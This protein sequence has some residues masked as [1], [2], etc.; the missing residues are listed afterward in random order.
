MKKLLG[1]VALATALMVSQAATAATVDIF[2]TQ[3]APGSSSW[4][5]TVNTSVNLGGV[6]LITGDNT[7]AFAPNPA[8]SSPTALLDLGL[9]GLSPN[10]F[11]TGPSDA[12]TLSVVNN[13]VNVG[14]PPVLTGLVVFPAGTTGGLLGTLTVDGALILTNNDFGNGGSAFDSNGNF[15][16]Y[17]IS[18]RPAVPEPVSLVFMAMGLAGLAI[19]R[20]SA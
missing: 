3:S 17:S 14:T 15:V 12:Q 13:A 4:A 2:A 18:V 19:A 1:M 7:T 9:T 10:P 11:A 6:S 8:L 20:R 16:D 5:L